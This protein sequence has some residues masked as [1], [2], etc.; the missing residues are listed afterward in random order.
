MHIYYTNR[1]HIIKNENLCYIYLFLS[2]IYLFV[3]M[4]ARS[5]T[6]ILSNDP[7]I[8]FI[9]FTVIF[10]PHVQ[11]NL[12]LATYHIFKVLIFNLLNIGKVF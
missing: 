3:C 8:T 1:F 12:L 9:T 4:T 2:I 7:G 10:F 6:Q 11:G 5:V